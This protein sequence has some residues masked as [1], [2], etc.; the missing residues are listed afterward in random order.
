L[1]LRSLRSEFMISS[2]ASTIRP[3]VRDYGDERQSSNAVNLCTI[4]VG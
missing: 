2:V 4:P 1:S 3:V